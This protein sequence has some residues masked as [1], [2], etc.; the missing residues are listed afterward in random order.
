MSKECV[1]FYEI[2]ILAPYTS[3]NSKFHLFL[4]SKIKQ[5][6]I[7]GPVYLPASM[8]TKKITQ[9]KKLFTAFMANYLV[10]V[11]SLREA[12][13]TTS[14]KKTSVRAQQTVSQNFKLIKIN[15]NLRS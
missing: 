6:L 5:L 12:V 10:A 15:D 3:N 7:T 8:R 4:D 2:F 9:Q 1:V 14:S 11:R 13:W